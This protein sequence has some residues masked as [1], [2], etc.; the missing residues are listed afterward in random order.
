VPT[1]VEL[2]FVRGLID[3]NPEIDKAMDA[4][5]EKIV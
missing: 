1:L 3:G 5:I 2:P 4:C